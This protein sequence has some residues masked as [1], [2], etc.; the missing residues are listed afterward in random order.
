MSASVLFA[1]VTIVIFL[2]FPEPLVRL[3]L[4]PADP[5]APRVVAAGVTLVTMAAVFQLFDGGQAMA[6]GLLRGIHDTRQPMIIA[7]I[8][9][10]LVGLPAGYGLGFVAGLQ[11][12]GVWLGLVAGLTTA[13]IALHARFWRAV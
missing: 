12:V 8:S 6:M 1:L 7:A 3:F 13:A 4:D 2:S 5:A 9:Y 11:G 10:W